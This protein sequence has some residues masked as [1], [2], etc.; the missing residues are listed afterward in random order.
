[1]SVKSIIKIVNLQ[2]IPDYVEL[3]IGGELE[4]R[5]MSHNDT[6][7]YSSNERKFVLSSSEFTT[8]E[9]FAGDKFNWKFMNPINIVLTCSL[10]PWMKARIII[11]LCEN[12]QD[13]DMILYK[14]FTKLQTRT[15]ATQSYVKKKIDLPS[16]GSSIGSE[17]EN[18]ETTSNKND[19]IDQE[20]EKLFL[21]IK[22]ECENDQIKPANLLQEI[23]EEAI[24]ESKKNQAK[25]YE[26]KKLNYN[27]V[28]TSHF[29]RLRPNFKVIS[30]IK[31]K[32]KKLK[33]KLKSD[34]KLCDKVLSLIIQL[35][36]NYRLKTTSSN[37]LT[38]NKQKFQITETKTKELDK[39]TIK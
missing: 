37:K 16:I 29:T 26:E 36:L 9:L 21:K 32:E 8:P 23:E 20:I 12:P 5:V 35:K 11:N 24:H 27:P 13:P 28:Q 25:P 10:Y 14:S 1:M 2:F 38:E 30:K 15:V 22:E 31:R 33:K 4:I 17:D 6:A 39:V 18:K 3:P 34:S 7:L 19:L